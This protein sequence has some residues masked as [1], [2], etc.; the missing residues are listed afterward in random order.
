MLTTP[1]IHM[2]SPEATSVAKAL[3][4]RL[5]LV[6]TRRFGFIDALTGSRLR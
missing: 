4:C 2:L 6:R 5:E 3:P 1:N